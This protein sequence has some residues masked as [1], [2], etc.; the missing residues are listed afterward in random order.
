MKR[1]CLT[2]TAILTGVLMM[3]QSN[4][5]YVNMMIG[6]TVGGTTPAVSTPFGMTQW[7]AA[8][9]VNTISATPYCYDDNHIIGFMGTH[10]PAIWMGDY[11]F[12]TLMPQIDKPQTDPEVRAA[13]L[14]RSKEAS[15]PYYY[16]VEYDGITTEFT[17]TSR[18]AIFRIHYP[19]GHMPLLMLEAWRDH[20]SGFLECVSDD[21]VYIVNSELM[22]SDKDRSFAGISPEVPSLKCHYVMHFSKPFRDVKDVTVREVS[23]ATGEDRLVHQNTFLEFDSEV[24][25]IRIG[26]SFIDKEQA[27]YNLD[28]EIPAGTSFEAVKE[29]VR[30]EWVEKLDRIE[31]ESDDMEQKISFYTAVVR[32]LQLPREASEYGR[33][34]S[35][36]D[37][38]IH[39]GI[40]Y[41]DYSLWDTFRAEHPFL[42]LLCPERVNGMMEALVH[43]YE[44]GGWLPKWPNPTYSGI[45]I[46]SPADIVI[47][48]AY[49]NGFRG[50]DL[51]KAY[52]A[53]RK[54]AF[55]A[56]DNDLE[57]RWADRGKW[58]GHVE[59]RGGLTNYLKL[60]YV[61]ADKT[62]ES[63]SRTMEFG[64]A[65]YCIA[66]M[67]KGLGKK[68]DYK[69][70]MKN[71]RNYRNLYNP[72]TG[73]FQARNSD[74]SFVSNP[75]AG[76][77]EGD[78]WT[79]RFCFMQDVA[80]GIKLMGGTDKFMA[81]LD[82]N[83]SGGHYVHSNEPGHHYAYLYDYCGRLDKVQSL[84]PGIISNYYHNAPDG[85]SGDDDCGQ[86]SSWLIFSSLGFYPV[87][88]ASGVYA[89]GIPAFKKAVFHLENGDLVIEAPELGQS[90]VLDKVYWNGRKLKEPFLPVREIFKGGTLR[91]AK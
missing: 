39:E 57:S 77:T 64:L 30:A 82:E 31:V 23:R 74:G 71:S 20:D 4:L 6:T 60:G 47:A 25:E 51:N 1:F 5:D 19:K 16:K 15:S 76:F 58:N 68:S 43:M 28:H 89:L 81:A 87:T 61:A 91:F 34:Y 40:F 8:T 49:V 78:R 86:M 66:Q 69:A 21:E 70:L 45:M 36:F 11:G 62:N 65:D 7:V 88:S 32:T 56:P 73:F 83:F 63:V 27:E 13:A 9:R 85:L 14:D 35:P 46:G 26:S 22:N 48:D 53:I 42:Q 80:G 12:M 24:I 90:P 18:A 3:A 75:N 50:Y 38:K 55:V 79:Y 84:I 54:D 59:S 10:Q 67:A 2:I 72:E 17:A 29:K 41:N 44:Q 33:Y 37:G 52:E